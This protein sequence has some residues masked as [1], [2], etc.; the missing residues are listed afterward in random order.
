[1]RT[2]IFIKLVFIFILIINCYLGMSQNKFIQYLD[3]EKACKSNPDLNIIGKDY[4]LLYV[5][6]L[7]SSYKECF[8]NYDS[9]LEE[10][11][12]G[13]SYGLNQNEFSVGFKTQMTKVKDI[14]DSNI[15]ISRIFNCVFDTIELQSGKQII[16]YPIYLKGNTAVFEISNGSAC[17]IYY[18][19]LYKGIV[20]INWLGGIVE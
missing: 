1:M 17:E 7:D 14:F 10:L 13:Y 12:N 19:K 15:L 3:F 20:Q 4:N 5:L 16:T 9:N 11:F 18:L 8:F 2:F 6:L